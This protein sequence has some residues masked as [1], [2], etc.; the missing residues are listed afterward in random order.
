MGSTDNS[1]LKE[2]IA[3]MIVYGIILQVICLFVPGNHWEMATGLWIGVFVGVGMA[4]HM[5]NSLDEALDRGEEG[6]QKYMRKAY[7][8]RYTVVIIVL[9]AAASLRFVNLY[10]LFFGVMGLK[11]S[12]Y[13]QPIMHKL[14]LKFKKS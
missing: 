9:V 5:K 11:L 14:F 13:L 6:A 3:V 12:A 2:M 7:A 1:I 8:I 4:V 10:T